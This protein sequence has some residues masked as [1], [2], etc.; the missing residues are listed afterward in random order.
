MISGFHPIR[1]NEYFNKFQIIFSDIVL[2]FQVKVNQAEIISPYVTTYITVVE[3]LEGNNNPING[4]M[5]A[6]IY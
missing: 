2:N 1:K 5:V 6:G 3:I 4:H